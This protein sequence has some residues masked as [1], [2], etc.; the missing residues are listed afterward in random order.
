[1]PEEILF[2]V[3][4]P[5]YNNHAIAPKCLPSVIE[6]IHKADSPVREIIAVDDCST[7]GTAEW[8]RQ[9]FPDV[10]LLVNPR[11]LG[12]GASC[13]KGVERAKNPW[14]MLLNSDVKIDLDV[15]PPLIDD[16]NRHP[17]LFAVGFA[18][19][20]ESGGKF[21]AR[22]RIVAKTGLFKT[23]NDFNAENAGTLYDSFYA[24]GGH[25]LFNREKFLALNGFSPVFA[26]FYWEDVDLS[27]RARKRGWPVFFDPRCRVVHYH[28]SSIGSA[29][30]SRFIEIMQTRNK[31]LFFWK[32]V[33]SPGLWLRHLSGMTLRVLT[34][35]IAGDIVFYRALSGAVRRIKEVRSERGLEKK[36]WKKDDN[37]LFLTGKSTDNR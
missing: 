8:I 31:M 34:S 33:S 25:A 14:V 30:S 29:N 32:N 10:D 12:F 11:N 6:L 23:R 9:T 35:W 13:L 1:M 17:E 27:Y 36:Y 4:I 24:C 37:D 19:F 22:K 26:P 18:S 5:F 21:E 16:I 7:D 15:I 20:N 3:V 28:G 2:S